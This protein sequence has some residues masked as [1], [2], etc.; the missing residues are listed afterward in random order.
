MVGSSAA[1]L[2]I[3]EVTVEINQPVFGERFKSAGKLWR[4]LRVEKR[5]IRMGLQMRQDQRLAKSC[6]L[7]FVG[8]LN[9]PNS[10]Q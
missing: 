3:D 5:G 1:S 4:C 8:N 10:A 2:I 7:E 9:A 6:A